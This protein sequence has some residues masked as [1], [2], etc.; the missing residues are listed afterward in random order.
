MLQTD[1]APCVSAA[2]AADV[3]RQ[4]CILVGGKGTRLG[5]LTRHTPKPLMP[6]GDDATFLDILIEQVARQGFDDIV[7]LAGHLGQFFVERYHGTMRD[8]LL[9][10][11]DFDTVLEA[12]IVIRQWAFEEYNTVRP[13]RAHAML[14]PRQFAE[15][16]KVVRRSAFQW[17]VVRWLDPSHPRLSSRPL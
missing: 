2:A 8:Q 9:A 10:N 17:V 1:L 3:I 4:A 7:L 11:E 6:I 15:G 12:R 16:L 13:H 5:E 14:T